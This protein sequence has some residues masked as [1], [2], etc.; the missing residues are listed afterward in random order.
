MV[1]AFTQLL[2]AFTQLLLS[3]FSWIRR[4]MR[5]NMLHVPRH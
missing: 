3:V 4:E 1:T 2:T 5:K